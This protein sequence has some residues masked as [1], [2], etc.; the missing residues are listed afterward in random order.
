MKVLLSALACC[1]GK[2]S[3]PNTGW[4]WANALTE[5]GHEVTVLTMSSF[6]EPIFATNPKDIDFRFVDIPSSPLRFSQRLWTVH[7]Y[8]RW[9]DAALKDVEVARQNYDV[10]HHVTW[11]SLHLG[12][13]LWRLPAPLV[14]GP[15]G[16]GQ[17]APAS[18][19]R[20]FGKDWPAES[21]RTASTGSFLKLNS[22][23]RETIR[24]SAVTFVCN[25]ATA[26]ACERL[27][28]TDVRFMMADGLSHEWLAEVRSQPA[29]T[30]V[31]LWLGRLIPRKAPTLAV[32][33]FAKLREAMPARM[34]VAGDGP[35]RRQVRATVERLGLE[36]D[37]ELLGQVPF[38]EIR[39]LYDS[40]SIFLFTSLRDSFGGQVLEALGRGLPV[41]ALD[42]QG[43]GDADTGQ[44]IMKVPLP[45]QPR[46]LPGHLAAAMQT[47]LC[48]DEWESRSAAAV[49]W[50]GRQ[51]WPAKAA[52]ATRVYEELLK[53]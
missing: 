53:G 6:R 45:P 22:R 50:A 27:G 11:A 26:L 23:S 25:S 39:P 42:H 19:W 28:A 36:R 10:V 3:E 48:D 40:A 37:V 16:G 15:I 38:D 32:E 20:Y 35:L 24:N 52:T 5:L 30:P 29:D 13:Q 41:V 33:A 46:D 17:T 2:G 21:L 14:Y 43:V 49:N 31:V 8:A 4:Q 47:V 51:V 44:A 18:Y 12:S 1:P 7:V 34:V 9:Q